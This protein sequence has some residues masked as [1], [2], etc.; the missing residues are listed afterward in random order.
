MSRLAAKSQ[1]GKA[2]NLSLQ[3]DE[4]LASEDSDQ[5]NRSVLSDVSEEDNNA[6]FKSKLIYQK[7]ALLRKN[8]TL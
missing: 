3:D 7:R 6:Y 2:I 1:K 4:D 5:L 8:L